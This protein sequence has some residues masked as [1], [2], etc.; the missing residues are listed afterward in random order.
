MSE[1]AV[2]LLESNPPSSGTLS[3][4]AKGSK[5]QYHG[6]LPVQARDQNFPTM[7]LDGGQGTITTHHNL[8]STNSQKTLLF[9]V[10]K[11]YWSLWGTWQ[12]GGRPGVGLGQGSAHY[13]N[14]RLL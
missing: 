1:S 2:S 7:A 11:C 6:E 14:Q 12:D 4:R 8:G 5:H 9:Q 3:L 10:A 13:K